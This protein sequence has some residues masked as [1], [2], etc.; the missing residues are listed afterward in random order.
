MHPSLCLLR[1]ETNKADSKSR[2]WQQSAAVLHS[3][4][5]GQPLTAAPHPASAEGT[6]MPGLATGAACPDPSSPSSPG[7]S[8]TPAGRHPLKQKPGP[9][10]S[11]FPVFFVSTTQWLSRLQWECCHWRHWQCPAFTK[12]W[13]G[14]EQAAEE[15]AEHSRD[16]DVCETAP[17]QEPALH[18]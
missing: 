7:C 11:F 3:C 18:R 2:G 17:L 10:F 9:F 1:P 14:L 8:H 15:L 12:S 16:Q 6:Q 5:A 4:S 13:A